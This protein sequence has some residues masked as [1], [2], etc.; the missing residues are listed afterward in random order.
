M[1]ENFWQAADFENVRSAWL[2]AQQYSH[3]KIIFRKFTGYTTKGTG[4][5]KFRTPSFSARSD[6]LWLSNVKVF[7][8]VKGGYF[9]TGDL[10]V[11]STFQIRGFTPGY[12]L[13]SGVVI[14]E[15]AGDQIIWNGKLWV[16]ADQIEPMQFGYLA[17]P[18]FWRSVLRRGDRTGQG[19]TVGP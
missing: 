17:G 6:H 14:P 4:E 13:P 15:Y 7:D 11:Y 12:T 16:L 2:A 18:V 1:L 8:T 19:I 5:E 9:T 10:D 3:K